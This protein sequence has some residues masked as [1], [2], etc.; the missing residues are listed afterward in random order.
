MAINQ[1]SQNEEL[2][3]SWTLQS[4][5]IQVKMIKFLN[6][7]KGLATHISL[8]LFFGCNQLTCIK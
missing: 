1:E 6:S 3:G 5:N 8:F 4:A 2:V 7:S